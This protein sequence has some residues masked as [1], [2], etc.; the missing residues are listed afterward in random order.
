MGSTAVP[1][2]LILLKI[3]RLADCGQGER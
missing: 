1:Q 2:T 3:T